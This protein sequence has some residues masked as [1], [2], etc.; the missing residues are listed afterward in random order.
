MDLQ[1]AIDRAQEAYKA[2][3]QALDSHDWRAIGAAMFVLKQA[4]DNIQAAAAA[5]SSRP[6]G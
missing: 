3:D 2:L 4:L 5:K 6:K 1:Q